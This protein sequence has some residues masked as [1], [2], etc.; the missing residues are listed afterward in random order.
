MTVNIWAEM[1]NKSQC[2]GMS[3]LRQMATEEPGHKAMLYFLEVLMNSNGPLTI[4]QLAGRFGSR[5]FSPEMRSAAGEMFSCTSIVLSAVG[6]HWWNERHQQGLLLE[7]KSTGVWYFSAV[8]PVSS[9]HITH[10]GFWEDWQFKQMQCERRGCLFLSTPGKEGTLSA[11]YDHFRLFP[12]QAATR[13]GSRSFFLNTRLSSLLTATWFRYST[14]ARRSR[15]ESPVAERT[16]RGPA[17][18]V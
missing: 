9:L 17:A 15:Q 12:L 2:T 6:L 14:A 3:I 10:C 11:C 16:V 13:V 7:E 4:S 1:K 18:A 8:S 5:S